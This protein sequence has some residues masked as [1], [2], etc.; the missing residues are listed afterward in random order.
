[1]AELLA[2]E[3]KDIKKVRITQPVQSN[4]VFA[5]IPKEI[6]PVLQKEYFFYVWSEETGEVRWMCSYDT[7]EEDVKDFAGLI[8][9]VLS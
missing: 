3:V 1:M 6:I 7:T 8:R 4:A 2:Q 5:I 9:R